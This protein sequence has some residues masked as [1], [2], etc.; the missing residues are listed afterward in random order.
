MIVSLLITLS[1]AFGSVCV[2]VNTTEEIMQVS[3]ACVALISLF[4]SLIFAP[5]FLKVLIVLTP[6]VFKKLS[7]AKI[8][9]T[10]R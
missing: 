9:A 7:I 1:I 5:L 6:V 8:R 4:C 10:Q 2:M 3:A